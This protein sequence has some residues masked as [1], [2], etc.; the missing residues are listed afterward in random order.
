M[1][2]DQVMTFDE[3][4]HEYTING[5]SFISVTQLLKKYNLS[6]NYTGIPANV[7]KQAA[8]RG[9]AVHKALELF[10]GGDRSLL[11]IMD[12]IDL[13]NNYINAR[14]IN[15][16]TA[17]AEQIYYD[18]HYKVAGTVDF[19]YL[20]GNDVVVADFKTT[21]TLHLDAVA[22]QLSIYNY[23]ICKGDALSYYFNKLKVFH[24]VNNKLYVKDVYTVDYDAVKALLDANLRNDPVFNYVKTTKVISDA[25]KLLV[26]Q[27]LNELEPYEQAVEKLNKELETVLERVKQ[28][29]INQKDYSYIEP[30]S[31]VLTYVAPQHRRS[32]D[33]SK[34]KKFLVQHGQDVDAFMRE[35]I[36]KDGVRIKRLKDFNSSD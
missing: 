23:L 1:N 12:E 16:G 35:T 31:F 5:T 4:N 25:D 18:T 32:L 10:I 36:T 2:D 21:S 24:F 20:D 8:T 30:K 15:L 14:N 7:L 33:S 29:M 22:W 3:D 17:K 13:F 26:Q 28:N 27:I 6:V 11:G 34:V 9:N 19:Q